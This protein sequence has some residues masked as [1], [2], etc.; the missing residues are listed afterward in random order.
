[1]IIFYFS[2]KKLRNMSRYVIFSSILSFALVMLIPNTKGIDF[3][4]DFLVIPGII[5]YSILSL[6]PDNLDND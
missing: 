5:Q 1:M 4:I 2:V 3:Y 6:Y